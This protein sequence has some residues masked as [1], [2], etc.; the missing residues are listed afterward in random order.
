[1]STVFLKNLKNI[2]EKY[3][4]LRSRK[5]FEKIFKNALTYR[6]GFANISESQVSDRKTKDC[7]S[8]RVVLRL[9]AKEKV[10]GPIPVSRLKKEH[11]GCSA[12]FSS[13]RIHLELVALDEP[14]SQACPLRAHVRS[15]R[16][17]PDANF[18]T[19]A[20]SP[21]QHRWTGDLLWS[22]ASCLC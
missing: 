21:V 17:L 14:A 8:S 19:R 3:W 12:L 20:L 16:S 6:L 7:A 10:A 2:P 15:L 5:N 1:M 22:N 4:E 18:S 9:L 11:C 13:A